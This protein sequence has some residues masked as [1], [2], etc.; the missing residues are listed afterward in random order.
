V[1]AEP[2][3]SPSGLAEQ[4]AE[5][6]DDLRAAFARVL[7][8][9]WYVLGDEVRA[10][11]RAFGE[12]AG[13]AHA[14]GV[15]SGTDALTLALQALGVG[16][17]D[18]V[19]VPS[20]ALPTAFGVAAS[21]ATV[22]FADVRES[23]LNLDPEEVARLAGERTRAVVAVH[24][25]GHPA[26]VDAI[27]GAVDRG[28]VAL[29][30]DCAQAH[31]AS[32]RGARAGTLGDAAAWS[33]YP[34]KNLGALGDGGAVT[35]ADAALA[36]RVRSL[37]AYG[38]RERYYSTEL[39]TNSRLD[40]LQAAL[41]GAKLPHLDRW[42]EARRRVAAVYDAALADTRVTRPPALDGA[43]LARHLYPV[44]VDDRD[45]VLA[46]LREQGVPAAI[47]YPIAAHDQ[48]CFSHLRE[49]DLPVTERLCGRLL[50][51]PMHPYVSDAQAGRV[52]AALAA[53]C[54]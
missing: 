24:L 22:R 21:G 19:I 47:H 54:G 35:T 9:G 16:A 1:P 11:E 51:L 23:D 25:Y 34:T 4:A 5:L 49:R 33:F 31:G 8:S 29:V 53:V 46:A 12:W 40:E 50:S 45:R 36:E 17:G 15:A 20:N 10:F 48:P 27:A 3:I 43:T 7:D 42:L 30:E 28:R 26:D 14:V 37:R 44:Q 41:L 13:V 2:A 6:R 18:E 52:A 32:L 39:G 38:E